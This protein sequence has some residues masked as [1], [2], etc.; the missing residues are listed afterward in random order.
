[1]TIL[2]VAVNSLLICLSFSCVSCQMKP[3]DK[4]NSDK[5]EQLVNT[6]L[7]DKSLPE[8]KDL[9]KGKWELVSGK[10]TV[11]YVNLKT[12]TLNLTATITSGLKMEKVNQAS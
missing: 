10:N 7:L 6:S 9:V 11:N 5:V 1:M 2:K 8:I 3:E 12:R 4:T